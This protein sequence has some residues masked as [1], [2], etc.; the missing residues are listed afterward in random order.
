MTSILDWFDFPPSSRMTGIWRRPWTGDDSD[1]LRVL[2]SLISL[3]ADQDGLVESDVISSH[4][5]WSVGGIHGVDPA[6]DP[7]T[8]A[9]QVAPSSAD[10]PVDDLEEWWVMA[11]ALKRALELNP[12][13]RLIDECRA[14]HADLVALYASGGIDP[15]LLDGWPVD[16]LVAGL[17]AGATEVPLTQIVA[18]RIVRCAFPD[19]DHDCRR[20]VFADVYAAWSEGWLPAYAVERI[21]PVRIVED[22][23]DELPR[24]AAMPRLTVNMTWKKSRVRTWSTQRLRLQAVEDGWSAKK[25]HKAS[26][27]KLRKY[28]TSPHPVRNP[29]RVVRW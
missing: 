19:I 20:D 13:A 23:P 2:I 9:I 28:L 25:A 8:L 10:D 21:Q 24:T 6:G 29:A 3:G 27:K 17:L 1:R 7:W 14:D 26:R 15:H 11:E 16:D 5:P 12:E 18:R 22:D 4:L